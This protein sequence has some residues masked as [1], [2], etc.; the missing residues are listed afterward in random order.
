MPTLGSAQGTFLAWLSLSSLRTRPYSSLNA[1][2]GIHPS[3]YSHPFPSNI[4]AFHTKNE[5][6]GDIYTLNHV[7]MNL[8]STLLSISETHTKVSSLEEATV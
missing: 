7:A 5:D 4:N 2:V 8:K 6:L 3:F 1:T